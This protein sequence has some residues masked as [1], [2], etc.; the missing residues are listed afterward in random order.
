MN[1]I[2]FLEIKTNNNKNI[3]DF[4][5]ETINKALINNN[6]NQNIIDDIE[7]ELN[8]IV[9]KHNNNEPISFIN[10]FYKKNYSNIDFSYNDN[11]YDFIPYDYY[12]DKINLLFVD[13]LLNS[14]D[15]INKL[16]NHN[17]KLSF[18]LLASVISKYNNNSSAIFGN[19]F[20]LTI[21]KQFY[22]QIYKENNY[23]FTNNIYYSFNIFNF[24]K[25]IVNIYFV[26]I[27][28]KKQSNIDNNIYY[29]SREILDNYIKTIDKEILENKYIKC[30][31]NDMYLYIKFSDP[32]VNSHYYI[33]NSIDN[34]NYYLISLNNK[35]IDII[36]F[37]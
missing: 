15:Y 3:S 26:K 36:K 25:S 12:D 21:D 10:D 11:F 8:D 30:L 31:H 9:I 34:N 4:L 28:V 17:H 7:F 13:K 37:L 23:E 5:I 2:E 14:T 22:E 24:I 6:L 19:I 35:D 1:I 29:Y 20:I 18:N 32:I 27:Y 33:L 16:D